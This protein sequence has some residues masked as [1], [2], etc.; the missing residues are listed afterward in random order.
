MIDEGALERC[1]P[2][3]AVQ[4]AFRER[5][6]ARRDELEAKPHHLAISITLIVARHVGKDL[7][8][9][10]ETDQMGVR[11]QVLGQLRVERPGLRA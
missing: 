10:L 6:R 9:L 1:G 5:T 3:N 8:P 7:E 11:R 2:W 4:V